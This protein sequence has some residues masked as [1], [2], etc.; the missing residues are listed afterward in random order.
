[1]LMCLIFSISM[2]L[3]C[4]YREGESRWN[5]ARP[6]S[7]SVDHGHHVRLRIEIVDDR[8]GL[9]AGTA[10]DGSRDGNGALLQYSRL[11]KRI[12]LIIPHNSKSRRA[13][14]PM[15]CSIRRIVWLWR[16]PETP[17]PMYLFLLFWFLLLSYYSS[18]C[19]F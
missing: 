7:P 10:R 8:R 5:G 16:R 17:I 19:F 3:I 18:K 14:R 9:P 11:G 2:Y 12:S 15:D 6:N 4:S 1:M 13:D